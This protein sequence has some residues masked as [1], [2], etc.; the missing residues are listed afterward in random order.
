MFYDNLKRICFE[1]STTV[2]KVCQDLGLSPSNLTQWKKGKTPGDRILTQ[3]AALLGVSKSELIS[4]E[5]KKAPTL[6]ESDLTDEE[7]NLIRMFRS[8]S[9]ENKNV[10]KNYISEIK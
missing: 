5:I 9:E 3:L 10:I 2:T 4:F 6:N 7:L 1:K 8:L